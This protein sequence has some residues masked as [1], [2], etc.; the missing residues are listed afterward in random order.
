MQE[1]DKK[2]PKKTKQKKM[3]QTTTIKILLLFYYTAQKN[4]YFV[5][6]HIWNILVLIITFVLHFLHLTGY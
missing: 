1:T 5:R 2:S 6:N 4:S 3:I